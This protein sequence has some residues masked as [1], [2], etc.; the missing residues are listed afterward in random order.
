M[1]KIQGCLKVVVLAD[2]SRHYFQFKLPDGNIRFKTFAGG[3]STLVMSTV[4]MAYAISQFII[5]WNRTSF[6]V[7]DT[8]VENSLSLESSSFG[9]QEN[10]AIAAAFVG[11][12]VE[13]ALDPEIGQLKFVMKSWTSSTD[14]LKF[15]D[16]A[17]R[18]CQSGDFEQAVT[19]DEDG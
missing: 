17:S 6:T 5:V 4:I 10:F 19:T 1:R 14:D 8:S 15:N 3:L 16:L 7:L 9:K 13:E 12:S 2:T 11:N 18:P